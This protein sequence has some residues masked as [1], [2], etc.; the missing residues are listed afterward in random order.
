MEIYIRMTEG[1]DRGRKKSVD[2]TLGLG[3]IEVGRAIEVPYNAPEFEEAAPVAELDPQR[4]LQQVETAVTMTR[5]APE[6]GV[7]ASLGAN[8]G[9]TIRQTGRRKTGR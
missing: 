2:R 3:M 8:I 9:E 6:P 7:I 1:R 5:E 4:M